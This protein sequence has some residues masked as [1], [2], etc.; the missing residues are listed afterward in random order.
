MALEIFYSYAHVDADEVL[1]NELEKHLSLLR[2]S[3]YIVSWHD[4]RIG[5][6]DE[7]RAQIDAHARSAHIILLLIS[8]DFVASDYCYDVE[9]ALALERHARH[10]AI[11]I[12]IILRP[13][14]WSGAPFAHLQALPRDAKAVTTWSNRDEAFTNIAQGIR[15]VVTRFGAPAPVTA[16]GHS[17]L[18]DKKVPKSRVLDAAI[19]SHIVKGE[20]TELQVLIRLPESVGL[21]GVLLEDDEAEAKPEDV[22]STKFGVTFP[23]G[24]DG[25]AE[26]LKIRVNLKSPDFNPPE[27]AANLFV[28]PDADSRV[29]SFVLTATRTG[30]LRMWVELQ[31]EDASQGQ[32]RL[33]TQCV[34]QA[35]DV[36]K[37]A[38][39]HVVRIPL[40]VGAGNAT[41]Q[42]PPAN[43]SKTTDHYHGASDFLTGTIKRP[44]EP[45]GEDASTERARRTADDEHTHGMAGRGRRAVDEHMAVERERAEREHARR[46][47]AEHRDLERK[48]VERTADECV[49]AKSEGAPRVVVKNSETPPRPALS[50]KVQQRSNL[51]AIVIA[52]ISAIPI[53]LGSYW[54]WVYKPAHLSD[55]NVRVTYSGQVL[56]ARTK[57]FVSDARVTVNL[58]SGRAPLEGFTDSKGGFTFNLGETKKGTLGKVYVHADNFGVL[59][60]NFVVED[61][62]AHDEFRLEPLQNSPLPP[63]STQT[64][65]AG[66]VIEN[67][68]NVG[69]G[70]A[71]ISLAGRP[72]TYLTDDNGN[73]RI[74]VVAPFPKDGVRLQVKKAGCSTVDEVVRPPAENLMLEL[75][76]THTAG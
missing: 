6:G 59:E 26:Q 24:A 34:A 20:P 32:R 74:N 50:A 76:C 54:Q 55:S 29:L 61:S 35:S 37:G 75:H 56:N 30:L 21:K 23:I 70:Q 13:T 52:L 69:V 62:T 33:V 40:E 2:R 43:A 72:E 17:A 14:D 19:P 36:P 1:R 28:P 5:A 57:E 73:F 3:G 18:V 12:P 39:R 31:W 44:F 46:T 7:W 53:V 47:A 48:R 25:R 4:R 45:S 64:M 68:T 51:S 11:V 15:D 8:S 10:E 71:S 22:R 66:R 27:Q 41:P 49:A 9:M 60:K 65:I 38:E 58:E 42:G 16:T 67:A 63:K